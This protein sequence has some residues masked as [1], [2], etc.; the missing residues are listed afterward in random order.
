[1]FMTS[2]HLLF[3]TCS[4]SYNI[5]Q[6]V[7]GPPHPPSKY[8]PWPTTTL[9]LIVTPP[10]MHVV[11]I[12]ACFCILRMRHATRKLQTEHKSLYMLRL[13]HTTFADVSK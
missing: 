5:F 8:S 12:A 10:H 6:E 2:D 4:R 9:T 11:N 1:M 7:L 13:T 3:A